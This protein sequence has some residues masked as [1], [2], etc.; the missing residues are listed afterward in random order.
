[1]S[2]VAN[3]V[4]SPAA[5]SKSSQQR[6]PWLSLAWFF[7]LLVLCYA[8]VLWRLVQQWNNDE[9]MGHGFFVPVIAAYIAWQKRDALFAQEL[10]PNYL[11]LAII[12][13]AAF[14]L[15]IGTLGA[16]LF[17]ARTAFIEALV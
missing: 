12:G 13:F 4:V 9:D 14:Q 10:K 11:G 8:P 7:G 5:D 16:E 2:S 15:W 6:P 1:M 17:L 3:P